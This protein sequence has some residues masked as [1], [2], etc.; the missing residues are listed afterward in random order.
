MPSPACLQQERRLL[1]PKRYEH[2]YPQ[3]AQTRAETSK[4]QRA[5]L[6]PASWDPS[7]GV[8]SYGVAVGWL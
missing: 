7:L 4:H 1:L 5:Q 8:L 3:P 2:F 6:T